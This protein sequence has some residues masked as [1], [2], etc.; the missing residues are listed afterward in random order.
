[1]A[2]LDFFSTIAAAITAAPIKTLKDEFQHIVRVLNSNDID[3]SVI[4]AIALGQYAT[5]RM[6]KDIDIL[7]LDDAYSDAMEALEDAGYDVRVEMEGSQFSIRSK[8]KGSFSYDFLFA[9]GVDPE[10]GAI[11]QPRMA[12]VLGVPK[13]P[14]PSPEYLAW[15][16]LQSI[17]YQTGKKRDLHIHDFKDLLGSGKLNKVKLMTMLQENSSAKGLIKIYQSLSNNEKLAQSRKGLSWGQ[18]QAAKKASK[19]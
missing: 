7:L 15:L 4:G 10:H 3:F 9:T 18:L 2:K 5:Q 14:V 11:L 13:V 12:T 1:M 8:Q 6:T 19:K 17:E 16:L